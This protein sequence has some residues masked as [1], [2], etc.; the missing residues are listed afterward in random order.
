ML[1]WEDLQRRGIACLR[2][3][4]NVPLAGP[5]SAE[6]RERVAD[7]I[8]RNMSMEAIQIIRT[9]T[10]SGLVEAKNTELHLVKKPGECHW[11]KSPIPTGELV[12]CPRC[13]SLNISL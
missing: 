11:C 13:R 7:A 10:G 6:G 4:S 5:L 9:D 3:H 2:C 1:T 12:D 8:R